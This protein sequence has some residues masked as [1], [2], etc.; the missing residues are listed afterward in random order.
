MEAYLLSL[1]RGVRAAAVT[2]DEG[3]DAVKKS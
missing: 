2:G 1:V 3:F